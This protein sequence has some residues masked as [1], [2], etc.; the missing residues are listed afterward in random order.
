LARIVQDPRLSWPDTFAMGPDGTLYLTAAQINRTRAFNA[1]E[2]VEYPY[3][4][5]KVRR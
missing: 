1:E 4:V 2:R 5:Y 3:R